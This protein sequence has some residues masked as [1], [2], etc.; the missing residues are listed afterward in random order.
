MVGQEGTGNDKKKDGDAA[1]KKEGEEK[2]KV[3]QK[4]RKVIQKPKGQPCGK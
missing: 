2:R 4:P 3:M 1:A